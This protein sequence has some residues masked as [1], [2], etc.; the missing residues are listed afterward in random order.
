MVFASC[1]TESY[2]SE[3]GLSFRATILEINESSVLV[4]YIDGL[5]IYGSPPL[6]FGTMELENIGAIVGDT[7]SVTITGYML[8]TYPAQVFAT[9]WSL[10]SRSGDVSENIPF[11]STFTIA[12]LF[13]PTKH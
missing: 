8:W 6:S 7:V 10:V 5:D 3:D 9:S 11:A 4:K 2:P 1:D 12:E 13:N